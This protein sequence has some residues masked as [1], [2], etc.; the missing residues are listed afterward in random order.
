M[1]IPLSAELA[2]Q[3]GQTG[4]L[5]WGFLA[6]P[7]FATLFALALEVAVPAAAGAHLTASVQPIRSAIRILSLAGNPFA[8]LFYAIGA[9]AFFAVEYRHATWRLIVPRRSR[10]ALLAAKMLGFG[11]CAGASLVLLLAGDLVASLVLPLVRGSALADVP[12]A[13]WPQLA[14][15]LG[16]SLLALVAFVGTVALLAVVTRS[17][18]GALLPAFLLSFLLAGMEA[19]LNI[20]G[21]ALV[22]LPLPT[23]A[24][25]AI[26]SWIAAT[27]E[28]PG[29]SGTSAAIAA[30]CLAGWCVLTYGAAAL[31]FSR[32]DLTTE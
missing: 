18:L 31:L 29:A 4:A 16:T 24:A 9:T 5:G 1:S 3:R 25:D 32:Q 13:T 28:Y 21:D 11:L 22:M 26:R 7:A 8:Q 10:T 15:A 30:A 23:L 20:S 19:M 6:V 27:A 17:T 14:R 2:K 12:P